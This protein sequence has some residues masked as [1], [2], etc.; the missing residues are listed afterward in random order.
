MKMY[1]LELNFNKQEKKEDITKWSQ[2][3][4]WWRREGTLNKE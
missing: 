3:M 1:F 2:E 4:E